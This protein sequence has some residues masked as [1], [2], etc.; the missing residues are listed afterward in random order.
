ML[1]QEVFEKKG[2][3]RLWVFRPAAA[4]TYSGGD[5]MDIRPVSDLRN[6]WTE[7]YAVLTSGKGPVFLTVNGRSKAVL[8]TMEEYNQL[9]DKLKELEFRENPQ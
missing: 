6:R 1:E 4:T 2:V 3:W 5:I 7:V 8:I 9:T